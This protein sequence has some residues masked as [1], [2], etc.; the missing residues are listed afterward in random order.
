MTHTTNLLSKN[1]AQLHILAFSLTSTFKVSAAAMMMF[2]KTIFTLL[3]LVST[4]PVV[5]CL[6]CTNCNDIVL[7]FNN[8]MEFPSRCEE[9][10]VEADVCQAIFHTNYL[11][12]EIYLNLT[13]ASDPIGNYRLN[14][15]VEDKFNDP[16]R[17]DVNTTYTRKLQLTVQSYFIS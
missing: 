1:N 11:T 4:M 16:K 17:M 15:L 12:H 5:A 6:L 7:S 9:K 2:I 14:L 10:L 13:G 8:T 3:Y